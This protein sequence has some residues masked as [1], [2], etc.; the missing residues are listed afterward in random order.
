MF[1]KG[2]FGFDADEI[3]WISGELEAGQYKF[4]VETTDQ[5]GRVCSSP[6]ESEQ[7]VLI[8]AAQPGKSLE[9]D[10]YD[11]GIDEIEFSVG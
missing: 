2:E 1:G 11:K 8:R 6:V 5:S 9:I 4:A 10:S 7:V 3:C